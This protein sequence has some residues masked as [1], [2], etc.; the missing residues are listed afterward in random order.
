MFVYVCLAELFGMRRAYKL[1]AYT[2]IHAQQRQQ[3]HKKR[4][5]GAFSVMQVHLCTFDGS[6]SPLCTDCLSS[7]GN[8]QFGE[9]AKK[10]P[11][12]H[13]NTLASLLFHLILL[14]KNTQRAL[15]ARSFNRCKK[16]LSFKTSRHQTG[17]N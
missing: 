14:I 5:F 6:F 8:I 4:E 9:R 15:N 17:S 12:S 13:Q 2:H 10:A 7:I 1:M 16:T 3:Q 11:E